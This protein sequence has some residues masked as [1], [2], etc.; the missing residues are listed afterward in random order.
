MAEW[1]NGCG[2]RHGLAV[3]ML[4]LLLLLWWLL[5]SFTS[6]NNVLVGRQNGRMV[7]GGAMANATQASHWEEARVWP[8]ADNLP[9]PG[10]TKHRWGQPTHL[11]KICLLKCT[12]YPSKAA[13]NIYEGNLP[14]PKQ[15]FA[16]TNTMHTL[17][18][19]VLIGVSRSR[20]RRIL[21]FAFVFCICLLYLYSGRRDQEAKWGVLELG[22]SFLIGRAFSHCCISIAPGLVL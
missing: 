6:R 2:R 15:M 3:S 11:K 16:H 12:T 19:L 4:L 21:H 1:Q 20:L 18:N 14:N 22:A 7:V 5:L 13:P 17:S 8:G 9:I 10:C